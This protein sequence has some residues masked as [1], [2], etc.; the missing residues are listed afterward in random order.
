[1][2]KAVGRPTKLT[3]EVQERIVQVIRA[4]NYAEVAAQCAG[5]GEA[6]F[7]RWLQRAEEEPSGKYAEFREAIKKAEAEAH[8]E[9]VAQVRLAARENWAA[10]MTWLERKYPSKWGRFDRTEHSAEVSIRIVREGDEPTI[11]GAI[12]ADVI[13][14]LP[15]QLEAP[16]VTKK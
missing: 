3:P 6:T 15:K 5:I 12:E 10:G 8:A 1:M 7:Y 9:A 13:E 16:L 4:G 14:P 2:S 11:E